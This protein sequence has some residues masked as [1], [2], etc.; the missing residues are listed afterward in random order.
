MI[1]ISFWNYPETVTSNVHAS[2]FWP[3]Q[4]RRLHYNHPLFEVV[5]ELCVESG[6]LGLNSSG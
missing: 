5:L 2:V 4:P 3:Y 1:E 6:Q